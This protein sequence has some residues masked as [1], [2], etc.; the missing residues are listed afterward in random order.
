MAFESLSDR[1]QS[2]ISGIGSGG[3]ITEA[4]LRQMMREIRLALLEADVN[5]QVVRQFVRDVNERALGA[6]VLESLSPAQQVL[7]IVDEELT[8]LMGGEQVPL[9]ISK[10]PP[11]VIMMAGLQGAGKTTTVGKLANYLKNNGNHRPLLVAGDVYRPAAIDQL[12]TIGE[13]LNFP[14]YSMGTDVSPVKIAQDAVEHAKMQGNDVV[15]IDTAGR[16]H[17]DDALMDELSQIK[18]AVNPD[19]ILL[20]VDAM[21]GQDATNVAEAFNNTLDIS[22]VIITKLDGDTRGGAALSIRAV[23]QKPIKFT[24]QGEQ[25]DALEP[26]YPDRMASRILGMGDMMTLIEKAQQDFDEKKAEEMAE[27]IKDNTFDFNDFLDQ[28]D[29]INKMGPLQNLIKLIPG[30]NKMPGLDDLD[31]DNKDMDRVKAI[32]YS[33]T[34]EERENPDVISQSRRRR[35]A[36]G[37]GNDLQKVN[38]MISQFNQTR[39]FMNEMSH[40]KTGRMEKMMRQVEQMG[41]GQGGFPGMGEQQLPGMF[42]EADPE[43]LKSN[44]KERDK[45][46]RLKR[47]LRRRR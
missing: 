44:R 20:T 18:T 32:I 27:R 4:D 23:T 47:A 30:M 9:N 34:P 31:L 5:F 45:Q 16:L 40:G 25:M 19:D 2:A 3:Q 42:Q 8:E 14:V 35:I 10:Q 33:M 43:T 36:A 6:D 12:E 24:G 11:T 17:V 29:Q 39:Q 46:R 37:S 41:G 26:F 7:K 28:M 15:I 22:G 13:Q 38:Q 21:T 1:L